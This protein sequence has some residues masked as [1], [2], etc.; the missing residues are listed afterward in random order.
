[1]MGKPPVLPKVTK[2]NIHRIFKLDKKE[3]GV[4]RAEYHGEERRQNIYGGLLFAQGLEAVELDVEKCFL[5]ASFH[6]LFVAYALVTQ[7]IEYKVERL[8]DGKTFC[9]RSVT[10]TQNGRVV[11]SAIA[12]FSKV[13]MIFCELFIICSI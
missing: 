7:P 12:N 2:Q 1:M 6:S 10:G 5:P 11:F 9:A 3:E 13:R 8:R 4:Y